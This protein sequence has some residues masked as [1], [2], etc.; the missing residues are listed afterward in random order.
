MRVPGPEVAPAA[1]TRKVMP[2]EEARPGTPILTIEMAQA[3][4]PRV[5]EAREATPRIGL[6]PLK[7]AS[8]LGIRSRA[9]G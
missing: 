3:L 9:R 4:E 6:P 7:P 8:T 5:S 1:T 2:R